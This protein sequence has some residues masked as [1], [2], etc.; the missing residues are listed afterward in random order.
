ML[1][2]QSDARS[3]AKAGTLRA[4]RCQQK[5]RAALARLTHPA[6]QRTA[7]RCTYKCCGR[8]RPSVCRT[9]LRCTAASRSGRGRLLGRRLAAGHRELDSGRRQRRAG[10]ALQGPAIVLTFP[11]R[12]T[13]AAPGAGQLSVPRRWSLGAQQTPLP[14]RRWGGAGGIALPALSWRALL[15]SAWRTKR[16]AG[17]GQ[18]RQGGFGLQAS[19]DGFRRPE[20]SSNRP[21]PLPTSQRP[22]PPCTLNFCL[23]RKG[24]VCPS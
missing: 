2:L 3:G 17:G 7:C 22:A 12:Q 11:P 6:L 15:W 4:K 9:A 21:S 13:T 19:G 14:V 16:P 1:G 8:S 5:R 20:A 24:F 10:P 18:R 23:D